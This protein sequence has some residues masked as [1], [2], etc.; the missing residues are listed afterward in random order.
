MN[1]QEGC[2]VSSV[3]NKFEKDIFHFGNT[4][5][6]GGALNLDGANLVVTED[7]WERGANFAAVTHPPVI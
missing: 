2:P 3:T 1:L 5:V 4:S 6:V 7:A